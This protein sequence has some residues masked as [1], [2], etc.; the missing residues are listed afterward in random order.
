MERAYNFLKNTLNE[1]DTV[2]VAVSAGV[3]TSFGFTEDKRIKAGKQFV[4]VGI[5]EEN[6]VGLISGIAKNGWSSC[7]FNKSNKLFEFFVIDKN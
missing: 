5:A 1:N 6:A 2:V 3:P 4:D 7:I